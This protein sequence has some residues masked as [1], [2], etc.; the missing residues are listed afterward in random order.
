MPTFPSCAPLCDCRDLYSIHYHRF[1]PLSSNLF[2][3]ICTHCSWIRLN[4]LGNPAGRCSA[5]SCCNKP[6]WHRSSQCTL[7]SLE[8]SQTQT[9]YMVGELLVLTGIATYGRSVTTASYHILSI[10]EVIKI[11]PN[12][13]KL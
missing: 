8:N 2:G 12:D 6:H 5:R 1:D 3:V 10:C 13:K 11:M 9:F 4:H 7:G